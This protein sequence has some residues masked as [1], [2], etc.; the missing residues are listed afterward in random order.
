[1]LA[2]L[3]LPPEV[4]MTPEN[5]YIPAIIPGPKEPNSE[6]LNY[7]LRPLVEDLKELWKGVHFFPTGNSNS[8][9]TI[10][11]AILTVIGNIVAI[12]KIT[13]FISHSGSRFC[14]FCTIHKDHIEDIKTDIWPIRKLHSHKWYVDYWLNFSTATE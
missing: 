12:R 10:Q 5:T 7:L 11:L 8:V 3:D 14:R 4:H 2:C 13:E 9:E 1:M 6:Q